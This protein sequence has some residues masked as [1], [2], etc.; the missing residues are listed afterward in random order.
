MGEPYLEA[1]GREDVQRLDRL[2]VFADVEVYGEEDAGE[3]ILNIEVVETLRFLPVIS[4]SISDENGISVGAGLK[5][6]NLRGKAIYFSGVAR[7]GGATTIE[8]T[9]RD[10]WLWGNHLGYQLEYYHRERRNELYKFD[11]IADEGFGGL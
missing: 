1:S 6:V 3:V 8:V 4:M 10:P 11:E 5:S 9:L 7:F 2:G